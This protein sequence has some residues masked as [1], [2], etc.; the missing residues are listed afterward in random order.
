M[1]QQESPMLLWVLPVQLEAPLLERL[2]EACADPRDFLLRELLLEECSDG[3]TV[4]A[5]SLQIWLSLE[6]YAQVQQLIR[7]TWEGAS[8][9]AAVLRRRPAR[10]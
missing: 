7:A 8:G 1:V 6:V 9:L 5:Q 10:L 3:Q 4:F 2:G